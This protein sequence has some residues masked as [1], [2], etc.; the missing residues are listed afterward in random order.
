VIEAQDSVKSCFP[1]GRLIIKIMFRFV[2]LS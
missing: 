2:I 1:E